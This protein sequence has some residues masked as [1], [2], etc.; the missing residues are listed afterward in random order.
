MQNKRKTLDELFASPN[1]GGEYVAWLAD[2]SIEELY[3]FLQ[4][5]PA[6]S[7]HYKNARNLL[8]IKL[9]KVVSPPHW[10]I[11]PGFIVG[12]LAM[13]FAAI[14]AIPTIESWLPSPEQSKKAIVSPVAQSN[15][16]APIV[17]S[18]KTTNE[19]HSASH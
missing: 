12:V 7:P 1:L 9:A 16:I 6:H 8:D 18:S 14:A 4:K 10:T 3:E 17:E 5:V 19:N 11:T 2:A 15:A 13:I